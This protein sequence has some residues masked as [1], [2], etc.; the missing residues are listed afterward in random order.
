MV[1]LHI[2]DPVQHTREICL[3]KLLVPGG[4]DYNAVGGNSQHGNA[5][6][7]EN[8][9]CY[10]LDVGYVPQQNEGHDEAGRSYA[11][12]TIVGNPS[13]TDSRTFYTNNGISCTGPDPSGALAALAERHERRLLRNFYEPG[14][15]SSGV[16]SGAEDDG[17]EDG[18]EEPPVL[19]WDAYF[20]FLRV[21]KVHC[22]QYVVLVA[23]E[24]ITQ[25]Q[26]IPLAAKAL[27]PFPQLKPLLILLCWNDLV[28]EKQQA[29]LA[30]LWTSY[31]CEA[32]VVSRDQKNFR[33]RNSIDR[34]G[35][36]CVDRWV[37]VLD[38][39]VRVS[40]WVAS[41]GAG[42]VLDGGSSM[43]YNKVFVRIVDP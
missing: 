34:A 35:D 11:G 7:A 17:R 21:Q 27:A 22:L 6:P 5:Q 38:Y 28:L 41:R 20:Q 4:R 9:D 42:E 40:L 1:Q 12:G 3:Q 16:S 2:L 13:W 26:N 24:F 18:G 33:G 37:G 31:V 8:Q 14:S 29:L 36:S 15:S 23:R 43:Q 30:H 19:F 32:D 39:K 25:H 10:T